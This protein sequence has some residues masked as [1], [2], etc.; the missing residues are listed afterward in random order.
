[1]LRDIFDALGDYTNENYTIFMT[2]DPEVRQHFPVATFPQIY[3]WNNDQIMSITFEQSIFIMYF[4]S[5]FTR[6]NLRQH[7]IDNIT[8]AYCAFA[9][10]G[11]VIDNVTIRPALGGIVPL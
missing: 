11:Q 2:S 6:L 1:M 7:A 4:Y 8:L 5:K 3:P 10:R 9:K